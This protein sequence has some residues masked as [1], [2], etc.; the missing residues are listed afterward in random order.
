MVLGCTSKIHS[1]VTCLVKQAEHHNLPLGIVMDRCVATS[2]ARAVP[3]ILINT[4]KQNIWLWQSL[5]AGELFTVEYHQIE[6]RANMERKG[7]SINISFLPAEPNT[8]RVQLEQLEAPSPNI[9][10]PNY[11][12]KPP[13][14]PRPYTKAADFEFEAK[15]Q[16]LPFKLNLGDGTKFI[17]VH[18][19]QLTGL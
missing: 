2:K 18:Q 7:E 6:Q 16:C 12:D 10:F 13:F 1:K 15:I 8:S 11:T 19:S 17:C 14:G 3:I 9:S 5:L 4:T